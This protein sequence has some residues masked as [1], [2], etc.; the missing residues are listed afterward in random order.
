[1]GPDGGDRGGT[2]VGIGTPE[3]L[4]KNPKSFTGEYL[5]RILEKGKVM[6]SGTTFSQLL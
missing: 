1:L 2:I 3:E 6:V 5:K 4:A